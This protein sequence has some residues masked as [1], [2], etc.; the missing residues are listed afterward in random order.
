MECDKLPKILY[1]HQWIYDRVKGAWPSI[2]IE[3]TG[4]SMSRVLMEI[5]HLEVVNKREGSI[6]LDRN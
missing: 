5:G 6:A 3:E 2:A 4:L 1:I